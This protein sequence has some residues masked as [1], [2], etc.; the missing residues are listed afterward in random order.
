MSQDFVLNY[1]GVIVHEDELDGKG[2]Y[3]GNEDATECIGEGGINTDEGEGGI[4]RFVF[5]E[6][7]SEVLGAE[8]LSMK[9]MGFRRWGVC[10]HLFEFFQTP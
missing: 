1:G 6:L 7:D 9:R 8:N 3:F 5:V 4:E 10:G 2:R